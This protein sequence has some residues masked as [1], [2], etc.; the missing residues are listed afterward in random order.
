MFSKILLTIAVIAF[1]WFGF[2]FLQRYLDDKR[3]REARDRLETRIP[4]GGSAP[5]RDEPEA[6]QDLVK[7]PACGTFRAARAGSCGKAGCP[8]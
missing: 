2:R 8:Y 4:P 3:R 6:V 1:I 7:C 5:K